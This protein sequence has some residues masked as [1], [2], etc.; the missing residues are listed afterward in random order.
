M[1]I[2][3]VCKNKK[4]STV[5]AK[6]F[7]KVLKAEQ[8]KCVISNQ[9]NQLNNIKSIVS[10]SVIVNVNDV[11]PQFTESVVNVM[12][13][14]YSFD[15]FNIEPIKTNNNNSSNNPISV[16]TIDHTVLH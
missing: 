10:S 2:Q 3:E 1:Q 4:L 14:E 16:H 6:H 7:K 5:S 13:S 12:N 8:H 11:T 9:N 15:M